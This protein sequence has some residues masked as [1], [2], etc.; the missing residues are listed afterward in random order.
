MK[1]KLENPDFESSEYYQHKL[2]QYFSTAWIDGWHGWFETNT[3]RFHY[4]VDKKLITI[5][6][7]L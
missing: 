2:K 4:H 7:D 3:M 6:E 1:E 5:N